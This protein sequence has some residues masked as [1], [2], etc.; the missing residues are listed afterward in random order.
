[1][2]N[3]TIESSTFRGVE[4]YIVRNIIVIDFTVR[5]IFQRLCLFEQ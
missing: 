2:F 1:M 3:W 5:H 4:N